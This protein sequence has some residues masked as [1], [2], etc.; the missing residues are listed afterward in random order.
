MDEEE[1]EK[2]ATRE[3]LKE[4]KRGKIRAEQAGAL[5][6]Q[7]CPLP[8]VNRRFMGN[9]VMG[10]VSERRRQEERKKNGKSHHRRDTSESHKRTWKRATSQDT[11]R[12]PAAEA[13]RSRKL[14]DAQEKDDRRQSGDR[15]LNR[16]KASKHK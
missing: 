6:W 3:L 7:T 1:L 8:K 4:A 10:T 9:M 14:T 16:R 12:E 11:Q 15:G 13:K 2:L 5:G